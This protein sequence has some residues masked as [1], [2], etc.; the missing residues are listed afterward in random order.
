MPKIIICGFLAIL[1]S[2]CNNGSNDDGMPIAEEISTE[3][4]HP[5]VRAVYES[6]TQQHSC[7]QPRACGVVV[8]LSCVPEVDGPRSYHDNSN[9]EPIMY[10][11]GA[12]MIV[13]PDDPLDCKSCPPV[14]WGCKP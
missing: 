7:D 9:G 1:L 6:Y 14:E 5:I 10:C 3:L 12:C 8:V 4:L 11:G 2:A 13:D